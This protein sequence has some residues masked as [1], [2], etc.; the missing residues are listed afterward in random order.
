MRE[1]LAG[2]ERVVKEGCGGSWDGVCLA[3]GM[4]QSTTP[5]LEK[6]FEQWEEV[7]RGFGFEFV[8]F[9]ARGRNE[10]SGGF[11]TGL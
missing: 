7:C 4:P 2:V 6:S 10:F 1:L 5:Y 11:F 9:E 8:D 3:V